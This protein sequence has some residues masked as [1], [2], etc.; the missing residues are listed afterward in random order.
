MLAPD[1]A[2]NVLF[3]IASRSDTSRSQ[4]AMVFLNDD[5][6]V[7][8]VQRGECAQSALKRTLEGLAPAGARPG[9]AAPADNAANA[10]APA[11]NISR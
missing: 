2:F 6:G 8:Q 11:G 10:A 7:T 5:Y 4:T 3:V 9:A 1:P